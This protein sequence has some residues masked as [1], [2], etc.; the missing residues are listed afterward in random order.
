MRKKKNRYRYSRAPRTLQERKANQGKWGRARRNPFHLDPWGAL[1]RGYEV[2]KSWK[3]ER[4]TQYRESGRR[5]EREHK[6]VIED[7]K[8]KW[9]LTDYFDDYDIPYR[10][11]VK[12]KTEKRVETVRCVYLDCPSVVDEFRHLFSCVKKRRNFYE[13][14]IGRIDVFYYE[15]IYKNPIIRERYV[16]T[17]IT[18]HITW[19]SDKDI[20]IDYILKNIY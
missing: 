9:I 15:C 13:L 12:N 17:G 6:I 10:I 11:L 19:W 20:G 5:S 4:K 16:A 14:S 1:E 2:T 8:D 7:R 3:D 18:Y